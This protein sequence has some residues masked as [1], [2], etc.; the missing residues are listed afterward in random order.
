MLAQR[1]FDDL[2]TPLAE[3]TFC[4]IDLETTGG[5]PTGCDI[6]EIGAMK[7][8]MGESLGTFQSLVDPGAPVPAFVRLLTG[9]SDDL[10]SGAP[11]IEV[12]L[13]S[14]LEFVSG[15]VLVAHNA[16]FDVGFLNAALERHGYEP[17]ANPI[18]DTARLARKILAGE[19]PNHKLDTLARHLRCAHRPSHRAFPDVLATVDVLHHLIER[20]TGFGVTTLEDLRSITS[21]RLDG[22]FHKLELAHD[23][24]R[25]RGVYRFLGESGNTLYVGKATDIRSRVRSYFYGDPRRKIRDL[26]RQTRSVTAEVCGSLLEA[27]IAEARAIA[28]ETPPYNRMGK[29]RGAWYVKL[30]VRAKVPKLSA[31]RVPKDDGS[32]YLGPFTSHKMV[33]SLIEA[34]Q[35]SAPIHRCSEPRRCSGCAFGEMGTCIGTDERRHRSML[36]RVARQLLV[37]HDAIL[38]PLRLKMMRMA[39]SGRFEEAAVLRDRGAIL[40]KALNSAIATRALLRAGKLVVADGTRAILF[41]DGKM[42]R[43]TDIAV[44]GESDAVERLLRSAAPGQNDGPVDRET[45]TEM[46]ILMARSRR[47]EDARLLY[48]ERGWAWPLGARP[49]GYFKATEGG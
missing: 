40:E 17:L 29:R 20:V 48:C 7:V 18:V 10:L 38:E 36:L 49:R 1:S 16:R 26:L 43:A 25:A 45:L 8:R 12:V 34:I 35:D 13:P 19:V 32:I 9:I 39:R 42:S 5:S 2:G 11:S 14:L 41:V 3:V 30:A 6:T 28:T 27:E 22:T 4:V 46:T 24:P 33:R 44:G 23:L 31:A 37:D 15:T 21:A 47:A